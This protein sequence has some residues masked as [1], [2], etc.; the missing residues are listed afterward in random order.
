MRTGSLKIFTPLVFIFVVFVFTY[1]WFMNTPYFTDFKDL[2]QNN[3]VLFIVI[4]FFFKTLSIIWPPLPG[5]LFTLGSIPFIGWESAYLVD[6]AGSALGSVIT[7][8][9]GMKYG[10]AFLRRVLNEDVI[11]KIQSIKVKKYRQTELI[12]ML[13]LFTGSIFLEAI[14]YGAGLLKI[15]FTSFLVGSLISHIIVGVPVYFFAKEAILN[16][17]NIVVSTILLVGVIF[18]LYKVKGRYLE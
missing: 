5:G 18:T 16:P 17:Q 15:R 4:L 8:Y 1:Y 7:Y 10:L 9:L 11:T 3:L 13:R 6:L 2:A 14:T 12:I